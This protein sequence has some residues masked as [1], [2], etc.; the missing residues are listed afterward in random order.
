MNR[1]Y[2]IEKL[3]SN[4]FNCDD[5]ELMTI[6][7][8]TNDDCDKMI[9]IV[10]M[11]DSEVYVRYEYADRFDRNV[12]RFVTTYFDALDFIECEVD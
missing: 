9:E 1:D 3:C 7:T 10:I 6:W 5:D 2:F 12:E 8:Y 4:K 11:N